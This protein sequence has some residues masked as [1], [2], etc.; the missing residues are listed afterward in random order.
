LKAV[1]WLLSS[2]VVNV[3]IGNGWTLNVSIH[4]VMTCVSGLHANS[5]CGRVGVRVEMG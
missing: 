3:Q 5:L 2:T 1:S 4:I